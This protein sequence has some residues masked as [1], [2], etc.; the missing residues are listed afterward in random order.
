MGERYYVSIKHGQ[1]IVN[2]KLGESQRSRVRL[3]DLGEGN[4]LLHLLNLDGRFVTGLPLRNDHNVT[5]VNL[6]NTVAL[7]TNGLNGHV[8]NLT[9]LNGRLGM[10]G[11]LSGHRRLRR[12][13]RRLRIGSRCY[14]PGFENGDSIG[15]TG[16]NGVVTHLIRWNLEYVA[17]VVGLN[18]R[19]EYRAKCVRNVDHHEKIQHPTQIVVPHAVSRCV[20]VLNIVTKFLG[21]L[22]PNFDTLVEKRLVEKGEKD[23]RTNVYTVTKCG[24]RELK[25]RGDLERQSVDL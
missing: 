7:V 14:M 20:G 11:F 22:Y 21:R 24:Q 3:D 19:S 4:I 13:V 18:S 15:I 16:L 10:I 2:E 6:R 17:P 9:L 23:R 1:A 25:P 8:P 12:S 5:T